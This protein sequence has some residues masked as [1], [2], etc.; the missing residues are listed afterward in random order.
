MSVTQQ[1]VDDII[2]AGGSLRVSRHGGRYSGGID[3]EQRARLAHLH[4]KVP[5]GKYLSV[6]IASAEELQIDLVEAPHGEG[7]GPRPVPI[8]EIVSKFHPVVREV[9][10]RKE[11]H[12]ISRAAAPRAMRIVQ[13]LVV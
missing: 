5:D 13:G 12:E 11:R 7:R 4:G 8:P 9:K 6:S 2:A 1:L 10:D 3:Y